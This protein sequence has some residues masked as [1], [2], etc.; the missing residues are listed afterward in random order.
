MHALLMLL[1]LAAA[2]TSDTPRVAAQAVPSTAAVKLSGELSEEVWQQA[3]V[4][5]GFRQREPT[6]GA[7]AT[8]DTEVRVAYDANA[9]FI[10]VQA[11]DADPARIGGIRTRRDD[12][13]PSDWIRV[14]IDSFHDHRSA[15]EFAVNPAGLKSDTYWYNDNNADQG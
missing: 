15:Y 3:P 6:E 7:A 9:I 2:A 14:M 8:Y 5:S 12:S 1:A 4:V 13:S 10:A 11:L